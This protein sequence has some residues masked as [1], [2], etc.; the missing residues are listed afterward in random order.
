MIKNSSAISAGVSK[1]ILFLFLILFMFL[2]T[3]SWGAVSARITVDTSNPQKI[4]LTKG[5]S[6]I[7]ESP[8]PVKRISI[9]DTEVADALV[10][11]PKEVYL[12]GK[13]IGKTSLTLW[14][15][16]KIHAI[17]ELE[18]TP[19]I[20]GLKEKIYE[21][22]PEEN[23]IHV[24]STHD[25]IVLSGS[26]S[27]DLNLSQILALAEAYVPE[28]IINLM[29]VRG[30]HQVMLEVRVAEMSRDLTRRMG[31]NFN[32][33]SSSGANI[34]ISML[35][36]LTSLPAEGW[37]GNAL[38]ISDPVNYLFSFT[39]DNTAW[40]GI[41]D[42]LKEEGLVKI[43]AEPTLIA[44]S[45]QEAR[46]LAG[47]EFPIPV[48]QE[49]GRTTIEYKKFGVGLQF[50]PT[51]L[52]DKKINM[53]VAPEVSELDFTNAVTLGGFVIPSIT[54]RRVSTMIELADGQSFAIAG[55]LKD[56]VREI[57]HKFPFLGDIPVIG[58]LFRS[59]DFQKNETELIIIVT[60]HLVKPLEMAK[61]TLPTEQFIEPDD[62]EFYLHGK[63]E[64]KDKSMTPATLSPEKT[65][66][67]GD[68][69]K[70]GLEGDFGHIT[71]E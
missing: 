42:A 18:I 52:S 13:S 48:P 19:D 44:L 6:V 16:S 70:G 29:Q 71:P 10:L 33:I 11:T 61:Q 9:V 47:G 59:T 25:S 68:A 32:Y 17:F 51:V 30:V 31:V 67:E 41:I 53:Q 50:T 2:N 38:A 26:V 57:I 65:T 35:N 69:K 46:F 36:N 27:S 15:D 4:F 28:K 7:L 5:K 1:T 55:L 64:G 12:T 22:F 37:P 3:K 56:N 20:A 43:L 8:M 24:T 60:P 14:V 63:I 49:L 21:I 23:D 39:S 62:I 45:G 34:G 66:K 40:T 58:T 54:T